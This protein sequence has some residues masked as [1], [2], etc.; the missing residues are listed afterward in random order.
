[1]KIDGYTRMAAVVANPIKHSL[2]PFIHNLAFDLTDENGVYLAWEVESEK[3]AAIV[4]NVRNLDMYGLNIS[5]PYK[6]EIIK[7]M[8]ELSPAAELIGA[9]NTVVNHSGKLIGHNTDGIGFF[10]SLKKY[11]F[12]IENKQI[13]VLGGGGAAIALIAQAALSGAKKIVVAARKS[14]SYDPLNEKLAKL[15][16]KTGVE[17]LLTDLSGA[18]RLQKEL[19]QTDLLVNA[20]S[21]GMDGAS[22]PLEK[23]LLLPDKLLVVD[24]IYKVRET[25]FLRWAKEQ[26]ART[27]NGLGMLIGQA[28]ESFYLW[29]GKEMPVDKITLEMEREA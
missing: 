16:S 4:E 1:M 13:L 9:V 15:S 17:I 27:E 8:D 14:A 6:G 26:G 29:T 5:M 22:F 10:N 20:T 11:D 25:P 21:V 18:D 3:L 28:A 23:S 12:K 19:N 7:F 2:S 24:A